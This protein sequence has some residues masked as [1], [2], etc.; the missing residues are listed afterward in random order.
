MSGRVVA[1]SSSPLLAS[2]TPVW[3]S[4]LIV[5]GIALAFLGLA[6]RAAWVQVIGNDF[7]RK[8]GEVRFARTLELPAN[9]GRIFDRNGL[10]LATSVPVPSVWASPEDLERDKVKLTQLARLLQVPLAELM[11]KLDDQ[12][13]NF[14]WLKRQVD[15]ATARQVT[16]LDIKGVF[17][18]KEYRRQYPEGEAA[19][20]VVGFTSVEDKGQEGVELAFNKELGGKPGSRHVIKDRLGRIV[21]DVGE[22]V[23]PVDGKDLQ[24]S[25]DSKV[26]FF[27]YQKLRDA[28]LENKARAGSVVVLDV[29]T[30]EVLALANY[31][32]Y[33]P[34]HRQNLT[35]GQLRN[36]ALT[37][38][39][40]PGSTMKPFVVSLALEKGLVTP[41]TPINTNG[42]R[43]TING[44]TITDSHGHNMLT[45]TEVVQKSSN[46]G[47]VK[48][49]MQL[50]PRE[51][52]ELY[53]QVGLGQR[54]QV[55]F[56]GV[57]SGKLRAYKTWRPIEQAT[58]SY[59]YGLSTSLFQLARA[60]TVFARDGELVP[61]TLQKTDVPAPGV[62]VLD[63]KTAQTMRQMLHLATLNGGTAPRAQTMGY[64][65]GGKTGTAHKQEGKGYAQNKYRGVFVGIAPI[66]K[67]RIVVAVMI[68]EPSNGRYF[69]GD[70]AAPVFSATVQQSLRM[71]GVQP[72]MNV[73]PQVV[74]QA[75]EESF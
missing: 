66:D 31:P 48:M 50:Q 33:N 11:A 21:E 46:I 29:H 41:N 10:L 45:V 49:A 3:R 23:P 43:M 65:V 5:A 52:W 17:L 16:A 69:G 42:G 62:R 13:K 73:K 54:P 68:D 12:E 58:M 39:F 6:G 22:Q 20:H 9:R 8:Q 47:T 72:D 14:V 63:P 34:A 26:Q 40:E 36:R 67:P 71:L 51:M 44:S 25:I 37:D 19:A 61:V 57:V 15:E 70:V 18:R 35:G 74:V 28:V 24:L 60:Y 59:G 64:S 56:P 7:Y 27:A 53:T 75:V 30:G 2:R 1:Y 38:T 32:S 4:K 55:P